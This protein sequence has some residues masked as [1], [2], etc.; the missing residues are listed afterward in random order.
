MKKNNIR[1]AARV[2]LLVLPIMMLPGCGALNWIKEKL[3]MSKPQTMTDVSEF[4]MSESMDMNGEKKTGNGLVSA[5]DTSEVLVTM[6]GKPVLTEKMLQDELDQLIAGR[7]E[8]KAQLAMPGARQSLLMGILTQ[9]VADEWVQRNLV[10]ERPEFKKELEHMSKQVRRAVS[11]K[12]FSQEHP[13]KVTDADVRAFYEKHKDMLQGKAFD[14]IKEMLKPAVEQE[15]QMEHF[16][17]LINKYKDEYGIKVNEDALKEEG[18][19]PAGFPGGMQ[20][21]S[22]ED[23]E[24]VSMPQAA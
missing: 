6:N 5:D 21:M 15:K 1:K 20:E 10:H 19:M 9:L 22:E 17:L 23:V 3:G 14:E 13:V 11:A 4:G 7:P 24:E 2:A 12:Y 8:L 16:E 18:A